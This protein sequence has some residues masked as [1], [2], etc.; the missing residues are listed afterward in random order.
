MKNKK[1][2][3][4]QTFSIISIVIYTFIGFLCIGVPLAVLPGYVNDDLGMGSLL[5]GLAISAQ[6]LSTLVTRPLAGNVA[7][8]LGPKKAV[9]YGLAGCAVS[10]L[11]TLVATSLEQWPVASY[12]LLLL[13]RVVLGTA[14]G[15]VGTG[16]ISWAISRVGADNTAQVISWNGIAAY[17]AMAVG[18]P[19]GVLMVG[20]LGIWSM[21]AFILVSALLALLLAK[22]RT[23]APII[24]GERMAFG[25]VLLKVAP[26]G[27]GL[28]LGSI[29][30]GTLATFITLYYRD[31]GWE[32]AA[33]CLTIFGVAFIGAR[34]MFASAIKR[35][36]GYRVGI[37]CLGVETLGLIMLWLAPVPELALFGAALTGFGL[38]LVY[39]ALGVEVLSRIPSS[40]RAAA[41]GAYAVFF[42]LALGIAGPLMGFIASYLGFANIFL[43][44]AL[45]SLAGL[46]LS[47]VLY[48]KELQRSGAKRR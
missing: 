42:D 17:G 24:P 30:F 38:S 41:L 14:Q 32:H 28:A 25:S 23:P 21:G 11:L 44:A 13:G 8:R 33:Y 3:P 39:P 2:T 1:R 46:L 26:N 35:I 40:S 18:A 6:Y 37:A 9:V 10:G 5:A 7:D 48:Q 15:M 29:G 47:V 22:N 4:S 36:G 12:S 34:L 20:A 43:A 19:L 31:Q 16:S 27:I 45:M